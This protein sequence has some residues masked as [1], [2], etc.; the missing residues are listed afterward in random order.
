MTLC[1][2]CRRMKLD[3]VPAEYL[4]L[5]CLETESL[6]NGRMEPQFPIPLI[7]LSRTDFMCE[8]KIATLGYPLKLYFVT[9]LKY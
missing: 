6:K 3:I 9:F 8:I 1:M 2:H 7:H 5:K 4:I